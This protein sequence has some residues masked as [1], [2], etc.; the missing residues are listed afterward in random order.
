MD[1]GAAAADSEI[2]AAVLADAVR[3]GVV[4]FV[5]CRSASPGH[6]ADAAD[7]V[8]VA[9]VDAVVAVV[10]AAAAAVVHVAAAAAEED[11]KL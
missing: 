4:L 3:A 1:Y 2:A 11:P 9:V 6:A 8:A 10:A 5:L 7:A